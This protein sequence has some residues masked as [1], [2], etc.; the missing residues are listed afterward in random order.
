RARLSRTVGAVFHQGEADAAAAQ[1]VLRVRRGAVD[2]YL[3][4]VKK[5]AKR[6]PEGQVQI[7]WFIAFRSNEPTIDSTRPIRSE[8]GS[9]P[10][11]PSATGMRLSAELS[12]LSPMTNRWPAGTTTSGVSSAELVPL[13]FRIGCVRP[14]GSISM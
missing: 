2:N 13:R 5:R 6:R 9:N 7:G 11:P 8:T 12:R 1:A 10:T 4:A 14:P 3:I